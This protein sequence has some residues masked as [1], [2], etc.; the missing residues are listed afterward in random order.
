MKIDRVEDRKF[1][2][3]IT[4][5]EALILADDD[6]QTFLDRKMLCVRFGNHVLDY[7][8]ESCKF[9]HDK[10]PTLELEL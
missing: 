5:K 7:I 10:K 8:C 6:S 9:P 2:I 1:Q 3:A 4:E